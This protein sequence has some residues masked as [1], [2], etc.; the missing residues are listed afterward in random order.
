[1]R[2]DPLKNAYNYANLNQMNKTIAA[3]LFLL[4]LVQAAPANEIKAM[5]G[6][7]WSKYLFSGETDSLNS[8][9][10]TGFTTGIGWALDLK[11]NIKL[12]INLFY[13]QKGSKVSLPYTTEKSVSGIY[14]NTTIGFPF[15]FKYKFKEKASPYAAMGPEL[16]FVL[17]HH[18][19]IPESG[20][21]FDLLN[22]TRKFVLAFNALLGYEWPIGQWGLFAEV[23]YNRWLSNF[24]VDPEAKVKSESFAFL[25][26]G[27]YY[28]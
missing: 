15:F 20:D 3:A 17:S 10:K 21:D 16:I 19:K 8:L 11:T 13:S 25:L 1:M 5:V 22:N 24:L 26:G 14:K 27:I 28:L 9:Q 18:L 23:R 7:N 4:L 12:E 6:M 2:E